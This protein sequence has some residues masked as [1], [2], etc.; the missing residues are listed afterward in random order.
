[1]ALADEQ[2]QPSSSVG[3]R[4]RTQRQQ[5]GRSRAGGGDS[6]AAR[7]IRTCSRSRS[8]TTCA[9]ALGFD[10]TT[11]FMLRVYHEQGHLGCVSH[12]WPGAARTCT[13]LPAL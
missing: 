5:P 9:A 3:V 6:Q 8:R 2:S 13:A 1:M 7:R 11:C 12:L 4:W 10:A